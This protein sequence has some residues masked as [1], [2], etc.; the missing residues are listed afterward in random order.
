[1]WKKRIFRI[2]VKNRRTSEWIHQ[3]K[4]E[5][6]SREEGVEYASK[7][8]WRKS[9][10]INAAPENR[11]CPCIST[12]SSKSS[13]VLPSSLLLAPHPL[14]LSYFQS[15]SIL[16]IQPSSSAKRYNNFPTFRTHPPTLTNNHHANQ[17]YLIWQPLQGSY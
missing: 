7:T 10:A 1:M 8:L 15:S 14:R 4:V 6:I 11:D 3:S 12:W 9:Q 5:V 17:H 13:L 16:L 2:T